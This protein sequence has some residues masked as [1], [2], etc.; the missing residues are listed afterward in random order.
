VSQQLDLTPYERWMVTSNL[1]TI[2]ET[3]VAPIDQAALLRA[4]G[5]PKI[6]EAVLAVRMCEQRCGR[7]AAV[8]ALD[9]LPG[10][11]GGYYCVPCQEALRFQITDRP[12]G[13]DMRVVS[14]EEAEAMVKDHA[15]GKHVMP[16]ESCPT[17]EGGLPL[18]GYPTDAEVREWDR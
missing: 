7:P 6:A 10:G 17:C 8:Y 9:P 13:A 4:N 14:R 1:K 16:I 15:A 18:S 11:W 5:Y 12:I 2:Q 3:G